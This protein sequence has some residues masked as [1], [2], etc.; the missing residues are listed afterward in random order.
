LLL[1]YLRRENIYLRRY[2]RRRYI[3]KYESTFEGT[4]GSTLLGRVHVKVPSTYYYFYLR[5]N[6]YFRYSCTFVQR[7]SLQRCTYG[8]FRKYFRTFES[9]FVLSYLRTYQG[10]SL[11]EVALKYYNVV[12]YSTAP[13]KV[14]SYVAMYSVVCVQYVL[15]FESD[16]V[17]RVHVLRTKS[18]T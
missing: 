7:C 2:L 5:N 12:Q 14:L 9:T 17:V 13:S 4:S 10:L 6:D 1:L 16:D 15:R 11:T 8:N 3:R 18:G